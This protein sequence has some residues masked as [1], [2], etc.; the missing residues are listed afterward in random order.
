[1]IREKVR[2]NLKKA[3][4]DITVQKQKIMNTMICRVVQLSSENPYMILKTQTYAILK[5]LV[6]AYVRKAKSL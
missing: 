3:L 5:K 6:N 4:Y 2:S 1:M